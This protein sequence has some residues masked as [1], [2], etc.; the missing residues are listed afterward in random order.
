MK[1]LLFLNLLIVHL[2]YNNAFSAVINTRHQ[3]LGV[4]FDISVVHSDTSYA[5]QCVN[6]AVNKVKMIESIISSWDQTSQTSAINKNAG[7]DWT[8]VN[9]E[10][11][12]LI[13][14]SK[15]VCELTQ[16]AFDITIGPILN[17]WKFDGSMTTIPDS[18]KIDQSMLKIGSENI[19]LDHENQCVLLSEKGMKIG[20]GAIGKGF[21]A[22]EIKQFLMKLEI[23]SGL[24][25]AG[26]DLVFWGEHPL[27]NSWNISV[28][29]PNG[30]TPICSLNL[31]NTAVVTSGDYEKF[32]TI[33]NVKYSHIIDPRTGHPASGLKSVTIICPN[34]E[35]AD[36]LATAVFVLGESKGIQLINS[37]SG[38]EA[39]I[40]NLNDSI[41]TSS[42]IE[43]NYF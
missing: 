24:I 20:F 40:I 7:L 13:N 33:D 26:G 15:N 38:I 21:I 31:K 14:R 2:S 41:L 35:L 10:L 39:I 43:P 34:A 28:A 8:R 3:L 1:F 12:S 37:L 32:V 4:N 22:E 23:T 16:G 6:K 17:C 11:F 36:A 29:N 5:W 30:G 25:G 42:G 19:L 9:S 27:T 18:D